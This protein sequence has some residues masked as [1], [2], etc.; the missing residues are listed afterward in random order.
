LRPGVDRAAFERGVAAGDL[1]PLLRTVA[2]G[3]GE[4]V[5]IPGGRVHAIEAGSFLL[6]IQ[7]NSDTTLRV[8]D[9]GRAGAGG[10]PRPLHLAAALETIRWNDPPA[11]TVHAR[12]AWQRGMNARWE[13]LAGDFFRVARLVVGEELLVTS[14]ARSFQALFVESGSVVVRGGGAE[15]AL[16][17]GASALLPAGL[18]ECLLRPDGGPA[19]VVVTTLG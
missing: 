17:R 11:E 15:M 10:A 2:L 9:W 14:D 3:P 16:E 19:G 8:F 13:I 7:Q 1:E 12:L 18:A 6:E 4:A 5:L